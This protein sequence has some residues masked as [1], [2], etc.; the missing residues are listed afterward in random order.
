MH[1]ISAGWTF[2]GTIFST[3]QYIKI[4]NCIMTCFF[5]LNPAVPAEIGWP[6]VQALQCAT[7][8]KL[9]YILQPDPQQALYSLINYGEQ[10]W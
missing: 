8:P 2:T 4:L 9:L 1:S 3:D 6:A 5:D 7:Q 10:I